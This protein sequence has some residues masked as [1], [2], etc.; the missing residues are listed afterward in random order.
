MAKRTK[1]RIKKGKK[2]KEHEAKA[3]RG[4]VPFKKE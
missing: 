1:I 2:L 3:M 4:K